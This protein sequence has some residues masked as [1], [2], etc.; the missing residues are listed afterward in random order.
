MVPE[1]E[2]E[3]HDS[4]SGRVTPRAGDPRLVESFAIYANG[5]YGVINEMYV[6][7][8]FRSQGVG[9]RLIAAVK[10]LAARRGWG[11]IDVTAPE[12]PAWD[13]TRRFHESQGFVFTGPKLK[14]VLNPGRTGA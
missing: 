6:A 9:G 5:T 14:F 3:H 12:S 13:R 11:R 7:P 10:D 8:P 4:G 2:D 1:A